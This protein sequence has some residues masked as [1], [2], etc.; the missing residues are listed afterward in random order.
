RARAPP[1]RRH[2]RLRRA[3]RPGPVSPLEDEIII[4]TEGLSRRFGD[5]RAV[6]DVSLEVRRGEIFGV[7]GPNGAGKFTT[8]RMLCGLLD[9]SGG[10]GR[11]VGHDIATEPELIKRRIGYMTQKFSLYED[12]T[13]EENL[14]FYGD[15]YRVPRRALRARAETLLRTMGLV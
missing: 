12:L 8:I 2:P 11:V 14:L 13:V 6:R 10:R 9:P 4:H 15:I 1:A 7:L 5:L 3:A